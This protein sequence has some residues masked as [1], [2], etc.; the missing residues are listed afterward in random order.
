[1]ATLSKWRIQLGPKR[2][3]VASTFLTTNVK[4]IQ[5]QIQHSIAIC[6]GL[7]LLVVS[8]LALPFLEPARSATANGIGIS[9]DLL[10]LP[11]FVIL[12][13]AFAFNYWRLSASIAKPL[14]NIARHAREGESS[15]FVFPNRARSAEE[16]A[17]KSF[18]ESHDSRY[19]EVAEERN[20]LASRLKKTADQKE[21]AEIKSDRQAKEI[22]EMAETLNDLRVQSQTLTAEA[23]ALRSA[24]ETER[25]TKVGREVKMR[26]EE[27]YRQ[28]GRAVSEASAR[29]VWIPNLVS[30]IETPTNLIND[31]ARRL[32]NTWNELSLVR[33]GEE[34]AEIRRQSDIQ[35][36]LLETVETDELLP[37]GS[38]LESAEVS[39]SQQFEVS[40]T[41]YPGDTIIGGDADDEANPSEKLQS[42]LPPESAPRPGVQL[43]DMDDTSGCE[44]SKRIVEFIEAKAPTNDLTDS[45][46]IESELAYEES[47]ADASDLEE[48][49]IEESE[50]ATLTLETSDEADEFE[51]EAKAEEAS[52]AESI[53]LEA[54]SD[55][56]REL[57]SQPDPET[58]SALQTL[59]FELVNDYSQEVEKICVNAEFADDIDIEV[60][61]ELLESV[62]SNLLE[63]A[64]YQWKEGEV[65][66]KVS[67]KDN[68]IT[69]A[70]DSKGEPL[71]Y[72]EMDESQTNRIA[73]ALDRKIDVDMPSDNEL[74]MRYRY[75]H[76]EI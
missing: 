66:L 39:S 52:E 60:D 48:S 5:T 76:E 8:F 28:V 63:I 38:T 32:E 22:D 1:M 4:D 33:L 43:E 3:I 51:P 67:S 49:I 72:G 54:S 25:K 12:I 34:I 40:E 31:I 61:E 35:C 36:S 27:I 71:D 44:H 57:A 29:A 21:Q 68:Q 62:L 7:N 9:T 13:G 19:N 30:K 17:F 42:T 69:F 53:Q 18:I 24:L 65:K 37:K 2:T 59:V 73:S 20:E 64:I 74:R 23:K 14:G 11:G 70:V 10:W 47:S 41:L 46:N 58:L 15:K 50:P 26:A 45:P 6:G 16:S 75:V 56:E 55:E